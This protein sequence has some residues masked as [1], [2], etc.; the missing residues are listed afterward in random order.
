[1]IRV[2]S[3]LGEKETCFAKIIKEIAPIYHSY[4]R[5]CVCDS[6]LDMI[7]TSFFFYFMTSDPLLLQ[8][9]ELP[10]KYSVTKSLLLSG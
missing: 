3:L 4:V 10:H 1:M 8:F 9:I 6:N 2:C 7:Q 5:V